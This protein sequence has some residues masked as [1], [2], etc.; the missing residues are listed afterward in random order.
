M[1]KIIHAPNPG[2]LRAVAYPK[3]S[4][5]LDA[6]WKIVTALVDGEPAPKDALDV[7]AQVREVKARFPK[8]VAK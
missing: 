3:P 5:Q 7:L 6:L 1:T 4:D 8:K 2:P